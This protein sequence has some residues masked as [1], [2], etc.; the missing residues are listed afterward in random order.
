MNHS[1]GRP[2]KSE[3]ARFDKLHKI[4]CIV[5][6]VYFGTF[7]PCE[8]HHL[9]EGNRRLGHEFTI[10]LTPWYHRGVVQNI[11]QETAELVYG[12]SKA[13]SPRQFRERFGSDRELL[14]MTN[15]LIEAIDKAAA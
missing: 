10:P 5:T 15:A 11:S 6:R 14:E 1:T 4:G 2:T 3:Q 7:S 13:I 8:I 9:V 12:P